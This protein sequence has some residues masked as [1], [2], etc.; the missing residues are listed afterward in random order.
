MGAP[1]VVGEQIQPGGGREDVR[2]AQNGASASDKYEAVT[3]GV[4]NGERMGFIG[5]SEAG[6]WERENRRGWMVSG[7]VGGRDDA[8][9]R[10]KSVAF[11]LPT[12]RSG[13]KRMELVG[14]L[15][16]LSELRS[17]CIEHENTSIR[18]TL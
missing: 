4:L 7:G 13:T 15:R 2:I 6:R 10:G 5:N 14:G 11:I 12:C 18:V 16:H 1:E 17:I 8:F 3:R 9:V